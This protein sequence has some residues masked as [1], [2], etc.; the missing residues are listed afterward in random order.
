MI[1]TVEE[2]TLASVFDHSSR[3]A[4]IVDMMDKLG[5]IRD[6][7]LRDQVKKLGEKLKKISDE[8]FI[9]V[10]FAVYEEADYE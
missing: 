4:A 6:P 2:T 3:R 5:M 7:E 8:D 9:R 1:F 10:D